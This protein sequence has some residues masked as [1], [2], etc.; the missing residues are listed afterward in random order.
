MAKRLHY[1]TVSPVVFEVEIIFTPLCSFLIYSP[2]TE[3]YTLILCLLD[4]T[5]RD[6]MCGAVTQLLCT[7]QELPLILASHHC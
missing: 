4:C 1:S 5:P 2:T 6:L 3:T 7:A